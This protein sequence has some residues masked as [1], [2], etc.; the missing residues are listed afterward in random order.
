MTTRLQSIKSALQIPYLNIYYK[1]GERQPDILEKVGDVA[2]FVFRKLFVPYVYQQNCRAKAVTIL[3]LSK[4]PKLA[5]VALKV[6]YVITF[7]LVHFLGILSYKLSRSHLELVGSHISIAQLSRLDVRLQTISKNPFENFTDELFDSLIEQASYEAAKN[8][9]LNKD[10]FLLLQNGTSFEGFIFTSS[11]RIDGHGNV[12]SLEKSGNTIYVNCWEL[13]ARWKT[14][15]KHFPI[16]NVQDLLAFVQDEHQK[17]AISSDKSTPIKL[18]RL[19]NGF[20]ERDFV[21][22]LNKLPLVYD[23]NSGESFDEYCGRLKGLKHARMVSKDELSSIAETIRIPYRLTLDVTLDSSWKLVDQSLQSGLTKKVLKN[24]AAN[25]N[26]FISQLTP[27][28]LEMFKI[29]FDFMQGTIR[30]I[31][32]ESVI[33]NHLIEHICVINF[34]TINVDVWLEKIAR[35]PRAILDTEF[36]NQVATTRRRIAQ[37]DLQQD[38]KISDLNSLKPIQEVDSLEEQLMSSWNTILKNHFDISSSK[39]ENSESIAVVVPQIKDDDL[40]KFLDKLTVP[41]ALKDRLVVRYEPNNTPISSEK[42]AKIKEHV[43]LFYQV[44]STM[45]P[46]DLILFNVSFDPIQGLL[47]FVGTNKTLTPE[48][49]NSSFTIPITQYSPQDLCSRLRNATEYLN[50]ELEQI[51]RGNSSLNP[52]DRFYPWKTMLELAFDIYQK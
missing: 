10:E 40:G 24:R 7:G 19:A 25:F 48:D 8:L 49:I 32:K 37:I 2:L 44:F 18:Y 21:I 38:H 42:F 1:E 11:F 13:P 46:E 17:A 27:Q 16:M 39:E 35:L 22:P 52:D 33:K 31:P 23:P 36:P 45:T 30:I 34:D 15:V 14:K 20:Y 50:A 6:V 5:I 4:L 29:H 41:E 12:Y 26:A 43:E 28:M 47:E 9:D 51:E 3:P